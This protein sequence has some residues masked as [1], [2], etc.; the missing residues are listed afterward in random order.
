M[1]KRG[2]LLSYYS[3]T[4]KAKSKAV[5]YGYLLDDENVCSRYSNNFYVQ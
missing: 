3:E 5:W 2:A 1:E 4:A